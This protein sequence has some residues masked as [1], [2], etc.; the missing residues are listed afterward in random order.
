[1]TE[2]Y[3]LSICHGCTLCTYIVSRQLHRFYHSIDR[4]TVHSINPIRTVI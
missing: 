4:H 3:I 1:M 2:G